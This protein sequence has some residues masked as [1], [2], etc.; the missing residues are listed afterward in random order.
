[1]KYGTYSLAVMV[2]LAVMLGAQAQAATSDEDAI[3][4]AALQYIEGGTKVTRRAWRERC[5]PN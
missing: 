2:L 3:K 4:A 5:I 1:M